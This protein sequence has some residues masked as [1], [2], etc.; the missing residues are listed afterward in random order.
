MKFRKLFIVFI[1]A[2]MLLCYFT[3]PT[4]QEFIEYIQPSVLRNGMPPVVEY[5]DKFLYAKITAMYVNAMNPSL[6]DGRLVA[7][8]GKEEYIGV[9]KK[10]WKLD[11]N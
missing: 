8:A 9:F 2:V 5:E 10:F 3:K 4:R 6:Q 7:G 1:L 11:S